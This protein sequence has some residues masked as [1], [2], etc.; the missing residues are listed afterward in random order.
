MEVNE[1]RRERDAL[2]ME[3]N[4]AIIKHAKEIEDERNIRRSLTT[5]NEK[6]K[7]KL[8]TLEDDL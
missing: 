4:E 8:R 2:K 7:F 5:D 3:K 6:L 1:L